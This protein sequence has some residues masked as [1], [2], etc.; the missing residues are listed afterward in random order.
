M[1][2]GSHLRTPVR[3][4]RLAVVVPCFNEQEVLPQSVA[5]LT[6]T[7]SHAVSLGLAAPGSYVLL[8]DDGSTDATAAIIRSLAAADPAMVKAIFLAANCGHQRAL[9]AGLTAAVAHGADATISIDADLQDDPACIP[10]MLRL[11][12]SGAEIVYGV[13]SRRGGDSWFKRNS[14]RAF[15]RLQS[16]MGLHTVPHHADCRL[17]SARA[18]EMLAD[19]PERNLYLRGIVP[20]LGL[21]QASVSYERRPR[22]S[23]ASHYPLHRMMSLAVDGITSFT[24]RPIRM[25]FALGLGI[26]CV[27]ILVWIYIFVS[28][29]SGNA[30][31]GWTS[32]M[33][34]VWFLGSLVLIALGVIGEY[35]GKIYIETK[36]RP[37]FVITQEIFGDTPAATSSNPPRQPCAQQL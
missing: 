5:T 18:V 28:K 37:P 17:L 14:A 25:I 19:Y 12:A 21:Q 33:L 8:C 20:R 3:P 2:S 26:L 16:L 35:V 36:R 4:P 1:D 7:I 6:E 31:S 23:G 11:Y 30:I 24:I 32:L 13:R 29:L 9:L 10:Q 34:S 27:D 22:P 15:Y